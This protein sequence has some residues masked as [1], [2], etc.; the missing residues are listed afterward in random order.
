[1]KSLR[2]GVL[3]VLILVMVLSSACTM[4]WLHEDPT[5]AAWKEQYD[6]GIA[7]LL[8]GDYDTAILALTAAKEI[9]PLHGDT[10]L[11]LADGY[12][13]KW[14]LD[15]A[16]AVLKN[17]SGLELYEDGNAAVKAAAAQLTQARGVFDGGWA[18]VVVASLTMEKSEA[19]GAVSVRAAVLVSAEVEADAR[20]VLGANVGPDGAMEAIGEAERLNGGEVLT[21]TLSPEDASRSDLEIGVFVLEDAAAPEDA[22]DYS[23]VSVSRDGSRE[24]QDPPMPFL[25]YRMQTEV[26]ET[27]LDDDTVFYSNT[28]SY[29]VFRGSSPAAESLNA[30]IEGILEYYRTVEYDPADYTMVDE[31]YLPLYEDITIEITLFDRGVVGIFSRYDMWLAGAH[32]YSYYGGACIDQETGEAVPFEDLFV[33]SSE[34]WDLVRTYYEVT[35]LGEA[36]GFAALDTFAMREDGV[37]LLY[38]EGDALPRVPILIPY[39]AED[40]VHI[41]LLQLLQEQ[42]GLVTLTGDELVETV[43]DSALDE[44]PLIQARAQL[45]I[46][47]INIEGNNVF[48]I[49]DEI[50]QNMYSDE[51]RQGM[52]AGNYVGGAPASNATDWRFGDYEYYASGDVLS[53]VYH[54]GMEYWSDGADRWYAVNLSV[55]DGRS[56]TDD[57]ILAAAGVD[58]KTYED[59]LRHAL[60]SKVLDVF[61]GTSDQYKKFADLDEYTR[62][63]FLRTISDENLAACTPCL[64]PNGDLCAVGTFYLSAGAGSFQ[65]C[66]DL[67]TFTVHPLYPSD[68]E[69]AEASG[70]AQTTP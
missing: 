30:Y 41:D 25:E 43:Y 28:M 36:N 20:L 23:L 55:S 22:E 52:I 3:A 62:T 6:A 19:D 48:Q 38:W 26:R 60:G 8:G 1:M 7:H 17:A 64:A 2:R 9:D 14:D 15:T 57:E 44:N 35:N 61:V 12:L 69:I 29:P 5:Q 63:D 10:Y 50:F 18:S 24:V 56:L 51:M 67:E 34:E 59:L 54:T 31:S 27:P 42:R 37:E 49:N 68:A 53:L 32:P 13:A 70:P 21:G 39:T 46:P 40:S 58:R 66:V 11:A 65:F 4:P 16:A 45:R 47:H 33:G